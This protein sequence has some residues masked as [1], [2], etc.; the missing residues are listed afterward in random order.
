VLR[1]AAAS[2]GAPGVLGACA[3]PAGGTT[4][5]QAPGPVAPATLVWTSWATDDYGKFREQRRLDLWRPE[6]AG[7]EV[8]MQN[9]PGGQPYMDKLLAELAAGGG[10]DV[11]RLLPGAV[12]P[13]AIQKQLVPLDDLFRGL[14]KENWLVSP[15]LRPGI[16]DLV[17]FNGRLYSV[18]MGG[19]MD[20]MLV[21]RN[22][23]R[24]AGRAPPPT[25][26]DDQSW[27]YERV[28]EDARQITKRPGG[29]AP[30]EALGLDVGGHYLLA[31]LQNAGGDL[32]SA[33]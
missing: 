17:R 25:G 20:G 23:F 21:N 26:Y 1:R 4:S 10:P 27:T 12:I 28:L 6:H 15:D 5:S 19:E 11:F 7:I 24:A 30:P 33:D 32:F 22:L 13:L 29:G 31:H 18:P 16:V 14:G 2:A 9:R 3:R 8:D